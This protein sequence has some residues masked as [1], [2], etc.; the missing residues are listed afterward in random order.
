MYVTNDIS[1][2]LAEW[3]EILKEQGFEFIYI[4]VYSVHANVLKVLTGTRDGED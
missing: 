1:Q 2:R 3:F 4:Y